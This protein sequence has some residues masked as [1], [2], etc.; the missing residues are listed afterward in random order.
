MT[1]AQEQKKREWLADIANHPASTESDYA[2]AEAILR[3]PYL[4]TEQVD[5]SNLVR[6]GFV[7]IN[8]DGFHTALIPFR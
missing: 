7:V 6:L 5:V 8:P 4:K 2:A 3:D 1:E